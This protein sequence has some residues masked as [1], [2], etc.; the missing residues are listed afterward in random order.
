M[1]YAAISAVVQGSS[2]GGPEA[3]TAGR[4]RVPAGRSRFVTDSVAELSQIMV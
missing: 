3:Q 2:P 4:V 1:I